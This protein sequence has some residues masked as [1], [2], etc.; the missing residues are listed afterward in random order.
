MKKNDK[1]NLFIET[2]KAYNSCKMMSL[3]SSFTVWISIAFLLLFPLFGIGLAFFAM[4]FLCIGFKKNILDCLQNKTVKVENV[5][6]YYKKS[7]SAFCLKIS[8]I[9]ITML[10]SLLLIIP[11]IIAGLNYSFAPYIFSENTEL[12]AL[13]CLNKSKEM[14]YGYRNEMF[15]I[16]LIEFLFVCLIALFF[17]SLLIL[18]NYLVVMPVWLNLTIVIFITM[19]IFLVFVFPYF[20]MML[21]N[22]YLKAKRAQEKNVKKSN[23]TVSK[24]Q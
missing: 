1:Y 19:F 14:V 6:N 2:N 16:Y 18:L 24:Q 9:L 11:G 20:E 10:W 13:E 22:V 15:L 23:K 4:C 12:H 17:S 5:F 8:S 21:A 3:L 7:I